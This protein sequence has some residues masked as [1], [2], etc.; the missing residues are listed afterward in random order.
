MNLNNHFMTF[1]GFAPRLLPGLTP[2]ETPT[3]LNPTGDSY[4]A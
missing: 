1:G 4:Q 2:L 3:R